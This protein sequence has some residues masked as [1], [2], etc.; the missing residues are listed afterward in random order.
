VEESGR[1]LVTAN[2]YYV[3]DSN[4]N[5]IELPEDMSSLSVAPDGTLDLGDGASVKLGLATFTNKD[6]L[7]LLGKGCY[8]KTEASGDAK[9]SSAAIS[10]G[11]LEGSNVNISMEFAKLIRTQRAYSLAGKVLTTWDEMAS[12]TNNIR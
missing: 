12:E 2:G 7:L 8:A 3:L 11:Y 5:R 1:Y 6:G 10:Q 4:G 9:E